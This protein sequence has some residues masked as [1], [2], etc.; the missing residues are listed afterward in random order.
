MKSRSTH[1]AGR[2]VRE[3][4]RR[5]R[6]ASASRCRRPWCRRSRR[7]DARAT[8]HRH[9]AQIGAGEERPVDVDRIARAGHDRRVAAV[10]QHPHQVAEALLRPDR[11]RDLSLGVELDAPRALV[12]A[13]DRLAQLG[14]PARQRVAV[15]A[16]VAAPPRRACRRRSP[17]TGCRGCRTRG[18]SR[19]PCSPCL[20]LQAVD[21]REDV[22]RQVRD[23]TELHALDG[24]GDLSP[25]FSHA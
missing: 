13:G 23:A 20:D 14:Q 10:E 6:A 17:A 9:L 1:G 16:R 21:D 25:R 11:V 7:V 8:S 18:R 2:V 5:A 24:G 4:D 12:V 22:R 15:V 19:L 3:R